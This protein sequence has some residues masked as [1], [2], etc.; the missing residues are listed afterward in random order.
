MSSLSLEVVSNQVV[1]LLGPSGCGKT[2]FLNIVAGLL[3]PDGGTVTVDGSATKLAG[4]SAYM[5]QDDLLLSWR[6]VFENV[7]LPLEIA[8]KATETGLTKIRNMAD[9]FGLAD[10]LDSYP[11]QLSGGMRQ[12]VAV[13]RAMVHDSPILLLDEPFSALDALTRSQLHQWLQRVLREE[14]R[15][16]ILV[17]HDLDEAL[18]LA[19]R[20]VIIGGAGTIVGEVVNGLERPRVP[21]TLLRPAAL[22]LKGRVMEL[23]EGAV[24]AVA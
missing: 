2:T 3:K 4:R 23:L 1:A 17:T 15:T 21:Q 11:H 13:M 10:V 8:G 14:R 7:R 9:R 6:T 16:T 18:T 24:E 5:M 19:D 12:R 20:V 22:E